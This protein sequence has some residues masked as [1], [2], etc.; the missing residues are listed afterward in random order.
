MSGGIASGD[1]SFPGRSRSAD[2]I[3]SRNE[4]KG[5]VYGNVVQ[6]RSIGDLTIEVPPP[7]SG[8]PRQLPP[9]PGRFVNR[10]RELEL[11]SS[12]LTASSSVSPRVV[13]ITGMTGV[14]KSALALQWAHKHRD[15]FTGGQ[16]YVDLSTYRHRGAVAVSD[17]L[18]TFLRSLAVHSH[19]VPVTL[20]E[21][22][23]LFRTISAKAPMLI[24]L[25]NVD[26]AAQVRPLLPG[27]AGG[28]VIVTSQRK[29][30][31]LAV[32]GAELVELSPFDNSDSVA[33]VEQMLPAEKVAT[34]QKAMN[35]LVRMCAGLP[36]AL[37]V[38]GAQAA[39]H[40]R[41]SVARLVEYLGDDTRRL[42]RLLVEGEPG[43]AD[44]FDL[45]YSELSTSTKR[46]YQS[47]GV[48]PGVQFSTH[49][50]VAGTKIPSAKVTRLLAILTDAN[51]VEDVGPDRYR[52]HDLVRLHA[53]F[54]AEREQTTAGRN[55]VLRRFVRWY[56]LG[57]AMADRA[58]LGDRW[59]LAEFKSDQ[60][61]IRFDPASAM[62][63]F[64][65]ERENLLE[66]VRASARSQWH[67][68]VWKFC[69]A[70]WAYY[71]SRKHLA[72]WIET[73]ELGVEAA[74]QV[75]S[76]VVET[77][78]LNQLARAH[79]ELRDFDAAAAELNRALE[80]ATLSGVRQAEAV[81]HESRGILARERG[82]YPAA[83]DAFR[84]SLRIN[85][86][87]KNKRGMAIESYHLGDV[88]C[89]A[90]RYE[91]A[92]T[93]LD[94]AS[95]TA[96]QI[97]DEMTA[98][99]IHI[100]LGSVFRKLDRFDDARR[101]LSSAT[102]TMRKR[103]QPIKEAQ[104]LEELVFVARKTHDDMLANSSTDRLKHI[105]QETGKPDS[106]HETGSG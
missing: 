50:L 92:L 80:A 3:S 52:L 67:D 81:V 88:L 16:L 84:T 12:L 99:R 94:V 34:E 37:R 5:S 89:Q 45:A 35:D 13:V 32:E 57:A 49:V 33:L 27:N 64:D 47:L 72:D 97:G 66:A 36:I 83:I 54:R 19:Y 8:T 95:R 51:L 65:T 73:H 100:V 10:S 2:A 38:A 70:L 103:N 78:M 22:A 59:R 29:L 24:L 44:I 7:P 43:V 106:Q 63:W 17:V 91:E 90:Q 42:E 46:L 60:W 86:A 1:A 40:K 15:R 58:V 30:S 26:Q 55:R 85:E 18:G 14:G 68:L 69:E 53:R 61:T 20:A 9:A 93:A 6:A 77:R 96:D 62:D 104:A 39:V 101:S 31:G 28:M 79:L 11:L 25:D 41:Q 82:E 4:V 48:H 74:R 105:Y 87:I 23:A 56:L 76:R 102:T 21:R 71:H 98:G 75:K